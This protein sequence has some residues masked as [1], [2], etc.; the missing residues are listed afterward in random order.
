[1]NI[2]D[3]FFR[4]V[5]T[6]ILTITLASCDSGNINKVKDSVFYEIDTSMTIGKAFSTRTDCGNGK[7]SEE[8]DARGRSIVIYACSLP[9][10]YLE[11]V[12]DL[13][14]KSL[15]GEIIV[16]NN[17]N[18]RKLKINKEK[19]ESFIAKLE[20]L[21][22]IKDE[23]EVI[24]NQLVSLM[25]EIE[26][27]N[28]KNIMHGVEKTAAYHLSRNEIEEGK[29]T[30][31][32][33]FC[34]YDIGKSFTTSSSIYEDV[35]YIEEGEFKKICNKV[36]QLH[37]KY[38]EIYKSYELK[39][40]DKEIAFKPLFISS[41]DDNISSQIS[42]YL[43]LFNSSKP[44]NYDLIFGEKIKK[45]ND[46]I[47]SLSL[48]IDAYRNA[49][50][51]VEQTN[52]DKDKLLKLEKVDAYTKWMVT[53]SGGV[54]IISS[55]LESHYGDKINSITFN[56]PKEA[57]ALAYADFREDRIPTMYINAM[58]NSVQKDYDAFVLSISK[59]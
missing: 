51:D 35:E 58:K 25:N 37:E 24:I 7:W 31:L 45:Y 44:V 16:H 46:R 59:K 40:V 52:I 54:E 1:M 14:S 20:M 29:I 17:M 21:T 18:E 11:H 8:K 5:L 9:E 15:N 41:G 55:G 53:D 34:K 43:I 13:M 10:R 23:M 39:S 42:R 50:I 32:D 26:K 3:G 49:L 56:K 33:E 6:I 38:F 28:L 30:S 36:Y 12:N 19:K 22:S 47:A 2:I 57:V 48:G 4:I 27:I